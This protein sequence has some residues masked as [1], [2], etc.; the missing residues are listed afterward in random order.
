MIGSKLLS[1]HCLGPSTP[2][3][4]ESLTK[5]NYIELHGVHVADHVKFVYFDEITIEMF[6]FY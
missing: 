6:A 2:P 4:D 1:L 5:H 3:P